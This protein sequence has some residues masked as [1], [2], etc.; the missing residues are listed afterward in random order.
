[1]SV[2]QISSP[3]LAES[4]YALPWM[5]PKKMAS[6]GS[7]WLSRPMVN[8]LRTADSARKPQCRHPVSA[9]SE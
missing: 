4:A 7:V 2:F 6:R 1:M 5:S 9:S 8:P 3:V